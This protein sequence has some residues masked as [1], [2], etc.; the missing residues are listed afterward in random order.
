LKK[1]FL[2]SVFAIF[3]SFF[4]DA[5][6]KKNDFHLEISQFFGLQ[7]GMQNEFVYQFSENENSYKKLSQLDWEMK[8]LFYLGGKIDF[9]YKNFSF[10]F[11]GAGFLPKKSGI[12]TDSDWI[13]IVSGFSEQTH[14]SKSENELSKGFFLD[15]SAG[16]RLDFSD[17]FSIKANFGFEYNYYF[18]KASDGYGWYGNENTPYYSENATFY[19]KGKLAEISLER[20]I[21]SVYFLINPEF[22]ITRYFEI[23]PFFKVAPFS[24]F[25]EIDHH[26]DF[27]SEGTFWYDYGTCFF[28]SNQAGIKIAIKPFEKLSFSFE[29]SYR[30]SMRF[31]GEIGENSKN[32]ESPFEMESNSKSAFE[33]K[34]HNF[35][36]SAKWLIF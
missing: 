31:K 12:M 15:T 24:F 33:Q 4:L 29:Y 14:L 28:N 19:Q 8:K 7:D 11:L 17:F 16:C 6:Q 36:I 25:K 30:F 23:N 35:S 18:F 22:H 1:S 20:T 26:F 3:L 32:K 9:Q 5:Q 2:I 13:G 27:Y 21:Y 34:I 10:N